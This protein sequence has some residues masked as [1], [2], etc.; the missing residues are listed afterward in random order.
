LFD[1][2]SGLLG[3]TVI[4]S[5]VIAL[6]LSVRRS[7][8]EVPAESL[9]MCVLFRFVSTEADATRGR[10]PV[11]VDVFLSAKDGF[12]ECVFIIEFYQAHHLGGL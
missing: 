11:V 12:R 6:L 4:V 3:R 7:V 5:L 10:L 1:G 9:R 8:A 2:L